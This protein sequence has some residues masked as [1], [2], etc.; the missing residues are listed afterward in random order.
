MY[1]VFL[2]EFGSVDTPTEQSI[3]DSSYNPV[4]GYGGFI[5]PSQNIL[6][7]VSS[8]VRLKSFVS[9][10]DL[11]T[12]ERLEYK[13]AKVFLPNLF[14]VKSRSRAHDVYRVGVLLL[15]NIEENGGKLYYYGMHKNKPSEAHDAARLHFAVL[16]KC[17]K[18]MFVFSKH[19]DRG[20]HIVLD[21]H[22]LHSRR[23][24]VAAQVMDEPD[25]RRYITEPPFESESHWSQCIQAADWICS[26]LSKIWAYQISP[27]FWSRTAEYHHRFMPLLERL[28]TDES[29]VKLE[30]PY[31]GQLELPLL[32]QTG[33]V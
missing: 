15:Q 22:T 3:K 31:D 8:F 11:K 32:S 18:H 19:R 13:G 1:V 6:P 10:H 28:K 27:D 4:F 14:S 12:S 17:I 16:R 29:I 23:K 20:V 2:D 24:S 26:I 21:Q 30:R 5:I 7:F 9:G 25:I 33:R